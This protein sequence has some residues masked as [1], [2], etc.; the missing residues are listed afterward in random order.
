MEKLRIPGTNIVLGTKKIKDADDVARGHITIG[1]QTRREY[2]RPADYDELLSVYNNVP[3]VQTAV[4]LVASTV[5]MTPIRVYRRAPGAVTAKGLAI[6]SRMGE[7]WRGS[8]AQSAARS[9]DELVEIADPNHPACAILSEW[10]AEYDDFSGKYAVATWLKLT[11]GAFVAKVGNLGQGSGELWP[12]MTTRV[13]QI[14]NPDRAAPYV[15]GYR[16]GVNRQDAETLYDLGDIIKIG[17]PSPSDPLAFHSCFQSAIHDIRKLYSFTLF[18]R[19]TLDNGGSPGATVSGFRSDKQ[20]DSF[21]DKYAGA[22]YGVQSGRR[23]LT[24]ED[25]LAYADHPIGKELDFLESDKAAEAR[26][27]RAANIPETLL[28]Q[29]NANLAGAARAP[30]QYVELAVNPIFRQIEDAFNA[31]LAPEFGPDVVF[32]FD[33][34]NAEAPEDAS[35]A[36]SL[37]AGDV[38]TRN[39]ARVKVGEDSDPDSDVFYSEANAVDNDP[40]GSILS[41]IPQRPRRD[42]P[43]SKPEPEVEPVAEVE[44][45]EAK[46]D[47]ALNG[48]QVTALVDLSDKVLAG[49]LLKQTAVQIALSAFPQIPP[50]RINIIFGTE[51]ESD[52]AG[53][54]TEPEPTKAISSTDLDMG[55]A[56]ICCDGTKDKG[57]AGNDLDEA[58][59]E[60]P[61]LQRELSKTFERVYSDAVRLAAAAGASDALADQVAQIVASDSG[62]IREN[63]RPALVDM[64]TEGYRAADDDAPGSLGS[65]EVL[66]DD[67][68]EALDRRLDTLIEDIG[69]TTGRQVQGVMKRAI[70]NGA[71]P[72]E[73]AAML[74]EEI[75]KISD[76]RAR[77]IAETETSKALLDGREQAWKDSGLVEGKTWRLSSD[78]CP[79]CLAIDKKWKGKSVPIGE[80]FV[81]AGQTLA[82]V[83]FK[84]D[85]YNTAHPR[86]R[87]STGAVLKDK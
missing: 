52:P 63:L 68:T 19:D 65:L 11:G 4:H 38:I 78:P 41:S 53:P 8:K 87:C 39:E 77:T 75:P 79:I 67:A 12:L 18:Q 27:Y 49:T 37:Y 42:E 70:D 80:P 24:L 25:G 43:G 16:Y 64:V 56:A 2:S 6:K 3:C 14:P 82:G 5:A 69:E 66:S 76:S 45:Q 72:K 48:A 83:T 34:V 1:E 81:K 13:W 20:A 40:F 50:E 35:V 60:V 46:A 86:C 9:E 17:T 54:A 22:F 44:E 23:L 31:S 62:L 26:V 74:R 51:A 84:R 21:K 58:V 32:M 61:A 29:Q 71:T 15:V 28:E 33:A 59:A 47:V 7:R 57:D 36:V 85:V 10:N 73:A 30:Q 55:T